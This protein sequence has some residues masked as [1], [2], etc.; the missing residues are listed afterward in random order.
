[1]DLH[2]PGDGNQD[3][4][5]LFR[6]PSHVLAELLSDN[7]ADGQQYLGFELY[8]DEDGQRVYY[9]ANGCLGYQHAQKMAGTNVIP[10]PISI[11][12]DVTYGKKSLNYRVVYSE[13]NYI[14]FRILFRI[15]FRR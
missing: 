2:K 11:Y 4:T 1:M 8:R 7:R 13:Y 6:D 3:L 10:V 15:L 9:E 5:F 14:S 12:V